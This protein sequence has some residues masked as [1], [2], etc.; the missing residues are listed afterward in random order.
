MYI[1]EMGPG[2]GFGGNQILNFNLEILIC[3]VFFYLSSILFWLASTTIVNLEKRNWPAT[4]T[5]TILIVVSVLFGFFFLDRRI[6]NFKDFELSCNIFFSRNFRIDSD[7]FRLVFYSRLV[8]GFFKTRR[9]S[10]H[11]SKF[12]DRFLENEC[13]GFIFYVFERSKYKSLF[14]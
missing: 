7:S 10:R 12:S 1:T 8:L 14:C 3:S 2:S 9:K 6:W 13:I 4:F 5:I 11:I